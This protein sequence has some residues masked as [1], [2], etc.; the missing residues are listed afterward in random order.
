MG[1]SVS[2]PDTG[3]IIAL[4][5]KDYLSRHPELKIIKAKTDCDFYTTDNPKLFKE[6]AEKF[7]GQKIKSIKQIKL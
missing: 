2:I 3:K 7:L 5:L 6:L 4:S 1:K